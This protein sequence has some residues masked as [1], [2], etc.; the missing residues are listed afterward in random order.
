M[1]S[2]ELGVASGERG[3]EEWGVGDGEWGM[4]KWEVGGGGWGVGSMG[5]EGASSSPRPRSG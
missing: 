5:G 2:G 1:G 3:N 4:E